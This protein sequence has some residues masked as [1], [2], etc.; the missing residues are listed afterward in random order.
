[1]QG[2]LG[3]SVLKGRARDSS[4]LCGQMQQLLPSFISPRD[5]AGVLRP[6]GRGELPGPLPQVQPGW[7]HVRAAAREHQLHH[8]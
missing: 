6:W 3:A 5:G 4:L 1:M 2:A 7:R 8:Q